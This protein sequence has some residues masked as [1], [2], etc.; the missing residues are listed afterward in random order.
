MEKTIL[1]WLASTINA[2]RTCEAKSM[3]EPAAN[4]RE[5]LRRL[6]K[7]LPSGSGID[8]GTKLDLD[9]S[10]DEKIVLSFSFHHMDESGGYA[11]WTE[12]T[13]TVR[14]SLV[15]GFTLKISGRDRNQV[16]DYLH[17]VYHCALTEIVPDSFWDFCRKG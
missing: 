2:L 1:A 7:L 9:K 4:H 3:S 14:P 16:K 6:E 17:D 11:G 10:T 5:A 13:V 15:F 8:C 12:H